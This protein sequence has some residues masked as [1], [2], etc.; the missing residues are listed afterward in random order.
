MNVTSLTSPVNGQSTPGRSRAGSS[1]G[2]WSSVRAVVREWF[3][4]SHL[5]PVDNYVTR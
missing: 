1:A 4:H 2:R 5:G 3:D